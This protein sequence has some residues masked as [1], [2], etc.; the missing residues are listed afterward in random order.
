[1]CE[2]KKIYPHHYFEFFYWGWRGETEISH[3]S[4]YCTVAVYADIAGGNDSWLPKMAAKVPTT[5]RAN[6]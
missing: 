1:M 6:M 3:L 2:R 5:L 4:V